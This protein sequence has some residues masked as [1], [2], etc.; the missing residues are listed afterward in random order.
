MGKVIHLDRVREILSNT[1][2]FRA[3]DVEIIVRDRAY[4]SV[5]L[6]NLVRRGEIGRITKGWYTFQE[7]PIVS[8]FCFRPAYIGLQEALSLLDQ[9]EQETNVIIV[10]TRRVRT[11]VRSFLDSNVVIHRIAQKYF[12]GIDYL[13]YGDFFVPISDV[14]KTL[15]DLVY[16]DEIPGKAV[17]R[18]ITKRAD[19]KKLRTYLKHYTP[20]FRKKVEGVISL[21][22]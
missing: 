9:W 7:D 10:T 19:R 13:R 17:F 5:L 1:P 18:E 21:L 20:K 11:G 8:V 15:I 22:S 6:H 3:K 4:S 16:F 2:V 14:E 12:F